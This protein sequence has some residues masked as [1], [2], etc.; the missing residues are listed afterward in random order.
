MS[1][2]R[3]STVHFQVYWKVEGLYVGVVNQYTSMF[4]LL[5]EIDG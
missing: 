4:H 5:P 3:I 2:V 1:I